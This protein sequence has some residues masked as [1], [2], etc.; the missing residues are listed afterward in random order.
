MTTKTSI[1]SGQ[2]KQ[3][4]RFVEDAADRALSEVAPDKDDL[5]RLIEQGD[6]LQ[7]DIVA[8]IRRLTLTDEFADEEVDSEYGYPESSQ[9][10]SIAEQVK[11]L[12]QHFPQLEGYDEVE[13]QREL[14]AGA[15]GWFAIPRWD[16]IA[17][18]YV[19]AV[20]KILAVLASSRKFYNYREGQL[21]PEHLRQHE[22]SIRFWKQIRQ[23]QDGDIL[24]VAAQFGLKHRGQSVHRAREIFKGNEFGL[25]AFA[26]SCMLFTNPG[27][28]V[29]YEDPWID[30]AGDEFSPGAAGPFRQAPYFHFHDG[31]LY[32]GTY[33][34][35]HGYGD[36]CS[37]SAFLPQ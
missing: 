18:T 15:E 36:F 10:V 1:T 23:L 25:G 24:I 13:A 11:I 21:G 32:F 5:Q 26:I 31:K 6:Q 33:W 19:E 2:E 12:Q 30:G 29:A 7:K 14:P 28:L 8:S 35:V 37:V 34:V 9:A 4:K 20:E 22:R 17:S 16:K 3:F 27:R